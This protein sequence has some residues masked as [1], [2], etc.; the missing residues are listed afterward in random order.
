MEARCRLVKFTDSF[1]DGKPS[2]FPFKFEAWARGLLTL[3]SNW[4]FYSKFRKPTRV[5][6]PEAPPAPHSVVLADN[7][8]IK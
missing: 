4:D 2:D 5:V 6:M 8:E 1:P 3:A 7:V